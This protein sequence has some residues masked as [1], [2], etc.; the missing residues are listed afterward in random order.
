MRPT[1]GT[2]HRATTCSL[3][4]GSLNFCTDCYVWLSQSVTDQHG[5]RQET[6]NGED[7]RISSYLRRNRIHSSRNAS[8]E[9]VIT[10]TAVH[11]LEG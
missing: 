1:L 6:D 9:P 7:W 11:N 8:N 4:G 2:S 3:V 5:L 10:S